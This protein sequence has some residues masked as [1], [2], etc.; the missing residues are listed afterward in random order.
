VACALALTWN[1]LEQEDWVCLKVK[2]ENED[3]KDQILG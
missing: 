3:K 2:G 1:L